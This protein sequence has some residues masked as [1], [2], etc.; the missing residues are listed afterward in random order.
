MIK[1]KPALLQEHPALNVNMNLGSIGLILL[2]VLLAGSGQLIFKAALNDIGEL[3]ISVDMFISLITSPLLI[4]GLLVFGASAVF[5]LIALMKAEL[6]FA[7]PFLGLTHIIVLLGG[8]VLFDEKITWLR[9]VGFMFIITG[10][11]VIARGEQE[12]RQTS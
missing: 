9:I 7:Y 5:W 2:S 4:L 12:Q 10:L 8:A 1:D 11:F 6:S 3:S